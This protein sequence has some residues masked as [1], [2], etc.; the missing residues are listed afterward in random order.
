MIGSRFTCCV[1]LLVAG[2]FVVRTAK[3]QSCKCRKLYTCI[4]KRCIV[5]PH[6]DVRITG[7]ETPLFYDVPR[8][9]T[10]TATGIEVTTMYWLLIVSRFEVTIVSDNF[11]NELV[12]DLHPTRE[13]TDLNGAEF[14]CVA[15]DTGGRRYEGV[16]AITVTGIYVPSSLHVE[17]V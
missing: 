8:D 5:A 14:K 6:T 13:G 16:I 7:H 10:C 17:M 1:L 9:I 4:A 11:V 12:L 15:V 2:N 3:A